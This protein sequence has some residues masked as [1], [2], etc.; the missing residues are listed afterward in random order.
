MLEKAYWHISFRLDDF[1]SLENCVHIENEIQKH[2]EM[3]I[4]AKKLRYTM[5]FFAPLYKNKLKNEIE[6]VKA[7][8][9]YWAKSMTLKSG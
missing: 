3:R 7:T 5:E 9:T 4:N 1:L 2:H 8:K 6:T